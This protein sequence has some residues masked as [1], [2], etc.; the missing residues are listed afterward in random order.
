[1]VGRD[2]SSNTSGECVVAKANEAD[3]GAQ[4]PKWK[5]PEGKEGGK[6][7][8]KYATHTIIED[9]QTREERGKLHL[10]LSFFPQKKSSF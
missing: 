5:S 7:N 2:A 8:L 9:E 6:S 3:C 4:T 10:K 1:V